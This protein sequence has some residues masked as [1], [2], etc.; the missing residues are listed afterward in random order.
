MLAKLSPALA[1][2]IVIYIGGCLLAFWQRSFRRGCSRTQPASGGADNRAQTEPL[3]APINVHMLGC[4]KNG[5]ELAQTPPVGRTYMVSG[6]GP[7]AQEAPHISTHLRGIL[8][9]RTVLVQ[10]AMLY[11]SHAT[12]ILRT[13]DSE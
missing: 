9:L 12:G 13:H 1:W 8:D 11:A 5:Q 3:N 2:G 4:P 6:T 10:V 7:I